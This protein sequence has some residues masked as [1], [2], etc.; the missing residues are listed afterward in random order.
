[1]MV[2]GSSPALQTL[3]YVQAAEQVNC[4][5]IRLNTLKVP[6]G[7]GSRPRSGSIW[8]ENR[9]VRYMQAHGLHESVV[10][11]LRIVVQPM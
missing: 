11:Q 10:A 9:Q 3:Q 5:F 1:M 4:T 2:V 6:A 7:L 8:R